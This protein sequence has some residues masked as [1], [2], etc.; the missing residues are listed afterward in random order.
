M[1][2]FNNYDIYDINNINDYYDKVKNKFK[3]MNYKDFGVYF[4][5]IIEETKQIDEEF[6][7]KL[8][9]KYDFISE[10][11]SK[12]P[13]SITELVNDFGVCLLNKVNNVIDGKTLFECIRNIYMY[14]YGYDENSVNEVLK[15]VIEYNKERQQIVF[16]VR[17]K[18]NSDGTSEI[19]MNENN[20]FDF[21]FSGKVL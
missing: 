7:N 9:S 1:S 18:I 2:K 13:D 6:Y 5:N 4:K 15:N 17:K 16:P 14:S 8:K 3:K 12:W 20:K 10:V 19:V 21:E 11:G